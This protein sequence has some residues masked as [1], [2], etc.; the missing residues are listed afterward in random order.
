MSFRRHRDVIAG[1]RFLRVVNHHNTPA[2]TAA[3]LHRELEVYRERFDP[4]DLAEL[5]GFFATGRWSSDR[6]GLLPVFYEGYRN[7]FDVALPAC[8]DTGF[9]GWFPVCT[10]FVAC[11]VAEQEL[12]ARSH[13][14]DLVAEEQTGERVALS[15]DELAEM[16][17]R[18]VVF[19]HT[20]S[21][22]GIADV[23]DDD[24]LEREIVEPKRFLDSITGQDCAAFVWLHGSP[25][26]GHER[27]DRAV[28][29]AG[30]RYLFSNTMIQRIR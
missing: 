10:G 16:S 30:Y 20:A 27:V 11:P 18:H 12:F 29:D 1:G 19:P 13:F 28:A 9:T 21:H 22:S 3:S 6:P 23:V 7:S 4:V 2:S 24:D 17:V 26:G 8:D 5:D 25:W 15:P 14:I